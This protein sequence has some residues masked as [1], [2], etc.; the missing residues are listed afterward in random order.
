[1]AKDYGARPTVGRDW[2]KAHGLGNDYLVFEEG[3][4]WRVEPEAVALACHR[5]EGVG[6][7]G[8]VVVLRSAAEPFVLRMFNPDGS[9]FERSGNGLRVLAAYLH[10]RGR[11]DEGAFDVE[12]GGDQIRMRVHSRSADSR[13]DI[14]VEMGRARV[15]PEGVA[16]D[17]EALDEQG[18]LAHPDAGRVP[19]VP[20]S[21]GNPH[22]VVFV[23]ALGGPFDA[24]VLLRLAT[25]LA[26]HR[27]FAH[28]A[29]VQLVRVTPPRTIDI[30]IWERGVGPTTASG[31]SACA[32]A[33]AAVASGRLDP[34]E[35]DVRMRG[36]SFHVRVSQDL[37]VV[38]RGP[39]EEV[40]S[41]ELAEG[42]VRSLASAGENR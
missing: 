11:V 24:T 10:H 36:G 26:T 21:V 41:G 5:H 3:E 42:F 38:L 4:G 34:G 25:G 32:S 18:R 2:Y 9:E 12:C 16:L 31:T 30:L 40:A 23:D 6:A 39:V 17:P 29:N 8:L 22:A 33:V 27:A 19:L 15:G 28:G 20:V 7:D 37:D 13:Y 1:M 14:E 35:V